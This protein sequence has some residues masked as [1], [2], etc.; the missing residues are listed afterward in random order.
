VCV[1]VCV[2]MCDAYCTCI[3][4]DIK[5]CRD[6]SRFKDRP[7]APPVTGLI[8]S[9]STPGPSA[10]PSRLV[11]ILLFLFMSNVNVVTCVIFEI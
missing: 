5:N 11:C 6:G 3:V 8:E 9:V 1:C 4:D 10:L 7:G 2:C